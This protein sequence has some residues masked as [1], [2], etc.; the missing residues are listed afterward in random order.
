MNRSGINLFGFHLRWFAIGHVLLWL[1]VALYKVA[2]GNQTLFLLV[3]MSFVVAMEV[4]HISHEKL[5]PYEFNFFRPKGDGRSPFLNG[6]LAGVTF[7]AVAWF[8][9][10]LKTFLSTW[11][12]LFFAALLVVKLVG[13]RTARLNSSS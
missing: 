13:I 5:T 10:F 8:A 12:M 9:M 1:V 2:E 3:T 6:L 4:Q 11:L 7:F